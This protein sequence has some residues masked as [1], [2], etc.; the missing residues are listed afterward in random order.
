MRLLLDTHAFLWLHT[1]RSR[2]PDSLLEELADPRTSRL[3]SVASAWE[4][5]IKTALGKLAV[6]DPLEQWLERRLR[7]SVVDTLNIQLAHALR[8]AAL[9]KHHADP[10][11]RLLVA[12]AQLEGLTLV[13][14]DRQLAAYDV[15]IRWS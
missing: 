12:Q 6:P 11:D 3:F 5:A 1:D 8:A 7:A 15:P 4:L 14:T 10:F 9:P 2:I 13:S